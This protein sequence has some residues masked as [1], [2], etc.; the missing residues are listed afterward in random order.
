MVWM[1]SFI[2]TSASK[3]HRHYYETDVFD[4]GRTAL[5]GPWQRNCTHESNAFDYNHQEIIPYGQLT[6]KLPELPVECTL[7]R[8]KSQLL[9]E[10]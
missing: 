5:A 8:D 10:L 2:G 9:T 3:S 7:E 6:R 4:P 1:A